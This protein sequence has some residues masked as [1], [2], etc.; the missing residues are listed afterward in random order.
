MTVF[1]KKKNSM[2]VRNHTAL[3]IY[4]KEEKDVKTLEIMIEGTMKV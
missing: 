1:P 4:E 2:I 3:E